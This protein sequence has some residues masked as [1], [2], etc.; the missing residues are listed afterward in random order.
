MA[1]QRLRTVKGKCKRH[2]NG[3]SGTTRSFKFVIK[4]EV[5]VLSLRKGYH[6]IQ[7]T[8]KK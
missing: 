3:I 6:L 7:I 5:R 2:Q 1:G 8:T 4:N